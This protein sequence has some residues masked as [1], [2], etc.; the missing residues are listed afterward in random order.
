MVKHADI[1]KRR[2]LAVLIKIKNPQGDNPADNSMRILFSN[3]NVTNMQITFPSHK[4][5]MIY[6]LFT[7]PK[8][9]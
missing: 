1:K 6:R 5:R 2:L 7:Y 4:S 8:E 3:R 9:G